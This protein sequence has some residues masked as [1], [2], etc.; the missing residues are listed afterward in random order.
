MKHARRRRLAATAI[1]T[2][3]G[4]LPV[5]CTGHTTSGL[6]PTAR[7]AAP[8]VA[9]PEIRVD[10]VGYPAGGPKLAYL[11]LPR[12]VPGTVAF[13]VAGGQGVVFRGRS[14]GDLGAWNAQYPA[15]YSLAFGGLGRPATTGSRSGPPARLR[16]R[17]RS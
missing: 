11:M 5:A 3:V 8:R 9:V 7:P 15:V 1:A 4:L 16:P 10:Q 13:T 6:A 14:G 2:S 12:R 17:R